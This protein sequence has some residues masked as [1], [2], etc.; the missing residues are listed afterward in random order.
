LNAGKMRHKEI[1]IVSMSEVPL[2]IHA[3]NEIGPGIQ[4]AHFVDPKSARGQGPL[5]SLTHTT[6]PL[7]HLTNFHNHVKKS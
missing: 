4:R 6:K 3:H 5:F 1:E 2:L 7:H